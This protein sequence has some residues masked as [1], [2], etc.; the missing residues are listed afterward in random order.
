MK[1]NFQF[2]IFDFQKTERGFTLLLAALVASLVLSIGLA[3]VSIARKSVNLSSIGRDSQFAFY[4]ADTASEC[5]L[6]WDIRYGRFPTTTPAAE[7]EVTCDGE[8]ET[9]AVSGSD[10]VI[11]T[12]EYEPNG[13][14]AQVTVTKS[15]T[16]P[17]TLIRAD[18]YSM[19]CAAIAT[20]PRTLQRSVEIRY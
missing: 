8:T 10:P 7:T 2:S 11:S 17:R 16:N 12:F 4:T 1:N 3:I 13:R 15:T 18:G 5:A 14:C 19:D 6:Y 20:N 9:L